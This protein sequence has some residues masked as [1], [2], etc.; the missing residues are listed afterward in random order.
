M[1]YVTLRFECR[2]YA[3]LNTPLRHYATLAAVYAQPYSR[4]AVYY[5]ITSR[6]FSFIRY[7]F[8]ITRHGG[9][10]CVDARC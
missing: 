10:G 1:P 6:F 4:H 9:G 5:A 3:M 8:Y 7:C 2:H